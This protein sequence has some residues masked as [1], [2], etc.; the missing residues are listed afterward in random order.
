MSLTR[1]QLLRRAAG[2]GLA[3][4]LPIG[5]LE[6]EVH[7]T[8]ITVAPHAGAY[9]RVSDLIMDESTGERMLITAITGDMLTITRGPR[10]R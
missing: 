7:G 6:P 9:F 10:W 8:F 1:A 3:L 2:A 5:W 4:A